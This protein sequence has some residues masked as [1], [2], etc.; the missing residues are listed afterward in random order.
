MADEQHH[1]DQ[2]EDPHKHT[3]HIQELQETE[4]VKYRN[5]LN[6]RSI[7]HQLYTK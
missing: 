1:A 6:V 7:A 2:I 3:G 4:P 5:G